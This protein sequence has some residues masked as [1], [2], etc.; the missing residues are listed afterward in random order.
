ME[1]LDY[2]REHIETLRDSLAE[3]TVLLKTDGSFP[4]AEAGELALFGSGARQTVKGG[5]GSGE[6]NSRYFVSVEEGLKAAGFRLTTEAWLD[7]YDAV[8]EQAKKD[9]VREIRS[10]A[11]R[12]HTNAIIEG[13]GAV[14]PE[15]EYDLPTEGGGETAVYVLAR[16]SGEGN[17]RENIPGDIALTKTEIRDI[18][19]LQK[20]YVAM[21]R[22]L[23]QNPDAPFYF[24]QIAP[25]PY[26]NPDS[27]VS[28]YLCEAQEKSLEVIPHS[29]MVTTLDIGEFG[30]IH[31]SKKQEIGYRLAYLALVNDYGMKGITAKAPTFESVAPFVG[32]GLTGHIASQAP[33]SAG[34][35][36]GTASHAPGPAGNAPDEAP[37]ETTPDTKGKDDQQCKVE[38]EF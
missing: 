30:T 22:D 10:R 4:L 28:G 14:M 21:M 7:A 34:Y 35:V 26:D 24:V 31:P 25:Y 16:T 6:V 5:T 33:G 29:G 2:E 12:N 27:W 3:C 38:N 11:R 32:S 1:L 17:D 37:L 18:L 8:R 19:R 13:M 20:E 23:F 15:P 36:P 9:F